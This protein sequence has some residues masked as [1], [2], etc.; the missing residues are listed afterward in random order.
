MTVADTDAV[1]ALLESVPVLASRVAVAVWA[2]NKPPA[3]PPWVIV[4]PAE[5]NDSTDRLAAPEGITHPS[6]TLHIVGSQAS[7][8]Q[9]ITGLVKAKFVDGRG[10]FV[11]PTVAGRLNQG[12]WWRAPLP[13][14]ID[15]TVVPAF[16]YQVI[17]LGWSSEDG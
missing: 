6:F 5:G 17:E 7:Q 10:S 8:A 1:V 13:L 9:T 2:A 3:D 11:P 16:V 14:Q 12:G 15:S 4:H